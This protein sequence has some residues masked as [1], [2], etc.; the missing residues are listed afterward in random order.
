MVHLLSAVCFC[1]SLYVHQQLHSLDCQHFV[2]YISLVFFTFLRTPHWCRV[3]FLKGTYNFLNCL[4]MCTLK[5]TEN[6]VILFIPLHLLPHTEFKG[7]HAYDTPNVFYSTSF[8]NYLSFSLQVPSV[9]SIF[10]GYCIFMT[11]VYCCILY[12][13]HKVAGNK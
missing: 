7:S 1:I 11:H 13:L 8:K 2:H 3:S 6:H 5:C 9:L 12:T 4:G 10:F